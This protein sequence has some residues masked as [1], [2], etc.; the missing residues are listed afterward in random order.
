MKMTFWKSTILATALLGLAAGTA[1]AQNR[2]Q[3]RGLRCDDNSRSDRASNCA[4]K[5]MTIPATGAI[6]IDGGQNGGASVRGDERE[7]IFIRAKIQ[8]YADTDALK[9]KLVIRH[10][11]GIYRD[12]S[13]LHRPQ[14]SLRED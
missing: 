3:E 10:D 9:Y 5:E 7:D 13:Y 8:T 6:N 11:L 14:T 4:I 12:V 1:A 2:S